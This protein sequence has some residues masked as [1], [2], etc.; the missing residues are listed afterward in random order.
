MTTAEVTDTNDG[1]RVLDAS[2][3]LLTRFR[4]SVYKASSSVKQTPFYLF[5]S[6]PPFF[7]RVGHVST[8]LYVIT[9]G[10]SQGDFTGWARRVLG[11]LFYFN[12]TGRSLPARSSSGAG[13]RN[14][15]ADAS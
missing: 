6:A 3:H 11:N 10:F 12:S 5:P 13:R 2:A 15:L 1:G 7:V 8:R 4:E 9:V 14:R